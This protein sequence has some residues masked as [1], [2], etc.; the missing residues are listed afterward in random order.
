[1][2]NHREGEMIDNK[3]NLPKG[4]SISIDNSCSLC[5]RKDKLENI[6]ECYNCGFLFCPG[7]FDKKKRICKDCKK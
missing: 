5:G 4:I 2:G 1:M 3:S 6:H 7:C